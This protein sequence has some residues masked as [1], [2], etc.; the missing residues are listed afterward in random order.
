MAPTEDLAY[1][2]GM[3]PDRESNQ[4]PLGSQPALNPLSYTSQDNYNI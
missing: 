3:C 1:S 2:P 4:W